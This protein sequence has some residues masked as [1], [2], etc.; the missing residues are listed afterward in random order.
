MDSEETSESSDSEK[1]TSF[2]L[3]PPQQ[4]NGLSECHAQ[5]QGFVEK[6]G[7]DDKWT[8]YWCVLREACLY[9]Y[10]RPDD[11]ASVDVTELTGYGVTELIDSFP[12]KPFILKFDHKDYVSVTLSL[13]C[14]SDMQEWFQAIKSVLTSLKRDRAAGYGSVSGDARE[15][16]SI[17]P[18][19]TGA[20][21][22]PGSTDTGICHWRLVAINELGNRLVP[23]TAK[24]KYLPAE[25]NLST[26]AP[27]ASPG[28]PEHTG[29][30]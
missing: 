27:N 5:M 9:F 30:F 23:T 8:R 15:S 3:F 6:R 12:G 10:L 18:P 28:A 11:K 14:H 25:A 21:N 4:E 20:D 7:Y 22:G 29:Q 2:T 16:D 26:D 24:K 1:V 19:L 17:T 13:D